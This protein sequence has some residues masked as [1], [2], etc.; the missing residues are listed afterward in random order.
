LLQLSIPDLPSF[1]IA[2]PIPYSF[3]VVTETKTL[4]RTDR[5]EDKHGKP[6]FPAPPIQSDKLEKIMRHRTEV[7]VRNSVDRVKDTLGDVDAATQRR[8][9]EAVVDEPEWVPKDAD[10]GRG[11]WRRSVHFNS[12]LAFH[13]APT[14]STDTLKWVVRDGSPLPAPPSLTSNSSSSSTHCTSLFPSPG[15]A[16]TLNS[17]SRSTLALPRLVPRPRLQSGLLARRANL[18][19]RSARWTAAHDVRLAFVS[20][21]DPF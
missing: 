10:K 8:A 16:T 5:P 6:L 9:V 1:P 13:F 7:R 19:G 17:S 21:N 15:S 20:I 3:H 4:D 18:C 11:F 2:T 12:T 14:F